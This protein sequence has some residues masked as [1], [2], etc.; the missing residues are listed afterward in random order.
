MVGAV[1]YGNAGAYVNRYGL[2]YEETPFRPSLQTTDF[3]NLND[4]LQALSAR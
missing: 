3:S 4:A 1:A 2:P